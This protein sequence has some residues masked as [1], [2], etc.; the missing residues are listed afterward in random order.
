[1]TAISTIELPLKVLFEESQVDRN[2]K[3]KV[4]IDTSVGVLALN[5]LF[6]EFESE[7]PQAIGFT[8]HGTDNTVSVFA[9]NKSN[10]YRIQ[11]EHMS[12]LQV[13]SKD[14]VRRVFEAVTDGVQVGGNVQYEYIRETLDTIQELEAKRAEDSKKMDCR[15]KEVRAI[16]ALSLNSCKTGNMTNLPALDALFDQSYR[17]LLDSMESYN[18]LS[19]KISTQKSTLN[20]LFQLAADLSKLQNVDTALSSDFWTNTQQSLR[21]RLQW[22]LR[23]ERGNEM[24]MIEK[25]CEHTEKELPRIREEK[26]EEEEEAPAV[27]AEA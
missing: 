4:T 26:E 2:A 15:M 27:V 24:A 16:E 10:R 25:L 7:N 21:E 20:S 9:A 3:Y 22:A 14:L 1:M 23:T 12:L 6:E 8:L 11:S 17:V 13:V 19:D 5:K 18:K